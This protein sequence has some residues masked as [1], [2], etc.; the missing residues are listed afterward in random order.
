MTLE[1]LLDDSAD[2]GEGPRGDLQVVARVA[3][4]LRLFSP[5]QPTIG[6]SEASS[7]LGLQKSTAHRYLTSLENHGFLRRVEGARFAL[8]P[9]LDQLGALTVSRWQVME[10]AAPIMRELAA[11]TRQTVVLSV[12]GGMGPVVV[13]VTEDDSQIVHIS[14]RVGSTLPYDSAQGTMFLA[15]LTDRRVSEN[16]AATLSP[17]R[18]A[19]LRENLAAVREAGISIDEHVVAGVR[20]LAVPVFDRDGRITAVMAVV[21]TSN[22]VPADPEGGVAQGLIAAGR[23]LERRLQGGDGAHD[24]E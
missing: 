19:A 22:S 13:R 23:L 24:P 15:H 6:L 16:L 18:L 17:E 12:W 21:G 10:A 5:T 9:L 20:A 8:G 11:T 3:A 14:V 4:V 1:D 2:T 7:G